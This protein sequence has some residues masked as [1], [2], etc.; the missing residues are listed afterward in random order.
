MDLF[1]MDLILKGKIPASGSVLDV[2]CGEG[3]NGIYFIRNGYEYHGWDTD[4]SKLSLLEY[5]AKSLEDANTM[6]LTQDIRSVPTDRT[7][8]L[9]VCSRL[10]HFAEN[11]SDFRLMWSNL[12]DL[13][14]IGGI[15]YVSMD[16]V[17]DSSLDV[18]YDGEKVEFPDGK[19]RFPLTEAIYEEMK[20]GFEEIEPLKTLARYNARA[21]SFILLR[22]I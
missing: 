8:D 9:I 10:L 13:L 17:V 3:R 11:S 16:S 19:I 15:V 20:K 22:K 7:F 2:G 14:T 12:T 5:L 18:K 4:A 6:F 21:Q 1:L